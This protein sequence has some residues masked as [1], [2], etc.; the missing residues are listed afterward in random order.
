M[1]HLITDILNHIGEDPT[2][3]GL[4]DTPKR[5]AKAYDYLTQ[6]YQQKYRRRN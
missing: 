2:R 1:E 6:G 5:V 4:K 3:P